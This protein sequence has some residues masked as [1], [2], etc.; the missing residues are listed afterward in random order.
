MTTPQDLLIVAMDLAQPSPP[1]EQG[2]LS[3]A[4]AGAEVIDLLDAQAVTIEDDRIVPGGPWTPSDRLLDDA[5]SSLVRQAPYESVEDWLWRRG[6]GLA[7][8]YLG[9][10]EA[11]GHIIRQRGRWIPVKTSKTAFADSLARRHAVERWTSG[12]PVLAALA[13]A[14]RVGEQRPEDTE[15]APAGDA[16]GAEIPGIS[17]DAVVAVLATVSGA[18]VELD[19]VRQRK[20]IEDA[21]FDNIWRAP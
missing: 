1:V 13:S 18:V 21:A 11:E 3:L 10:L 19:G 6:R 20:T 16:E 5:A 12:E 4:L 9:V 8:A 2:E 14:I 15:D 17:D 7:A